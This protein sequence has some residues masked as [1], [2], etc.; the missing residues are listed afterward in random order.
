LPATVKLDRIENAQ[1]E[2]EQSGITRAVRAAT[3]YGIDAFG[4]DGDPFVL[5]RASLSAGL[6]QIGE[7]FPADPACILVRHIV[8]GIAGNQATVLCVYERPTFTSAQI[9]GTWV[10]NTDTI[11]RTTLL[12]RNPLT[13]KPIR[14]VWQPSQ[15]TP[16]DRVIKTGTISAEIPMARVVARGQFYGL[17]TG[18]P[19]RLAVGSVNSGNW[20]GLG[21]GFWLF[22]EMHDDIV[23]LNTG[24]T[25]LS[26]YQYTLI[27]TSRLK[28]DWAEYDFARMPSGDF[29]QIPESVMQQI[30]AMEYGGG[31]VEFAEGVTRTESYPMMDLTGLTGIPG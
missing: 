14:V 25:N 28:Y 16:A 23:Q 30:R 1:I 22:D 27:F 17:N 3:I 12:Q 8:K 11:T 4:T 13:F 5:V 19:W 21:Q 9:V 10:I 2:R 29:A 31:D 26:L 15:Q 24:N 6:P 20:Q 7:A 18:R